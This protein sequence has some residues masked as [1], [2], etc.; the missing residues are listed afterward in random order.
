MADRHLH[1]IAREEARSLVL[2]GN[3]SP[4][5]EGPEGPPLHVSGGMPAGGS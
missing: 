2:S 5:D 4:A 1:A 3:V